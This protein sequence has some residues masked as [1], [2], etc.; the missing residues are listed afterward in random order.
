LEFRRELDVQQM[1]L[2][3]VLEGKLEVV[4]IDKIE[5]TIS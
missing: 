3:G 1:A 2:L 5:D 4:N